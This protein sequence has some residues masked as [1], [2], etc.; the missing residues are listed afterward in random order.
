MKIQ[1]LIDRIYAL[2][3]D[4]EILLEGKVKAVE[5]IVVPVENGEEVAGYM[6]TRAADPQQLKLPFSGNVF[7]EP[8]DSIGE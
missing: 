5:F 3:R 2:P 8:K 7:D 6:I 4:A 1:E